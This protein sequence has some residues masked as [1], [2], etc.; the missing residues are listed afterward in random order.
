[1]CRNIRMHTSSVV[2]V[3]HNADTASM[4]IHSAGNLPCGVNRTSGKPFL[5]CH[6]GVRAR[7]SSAAPVRSG[8]DVELLVASPFV[9]QISHANSRFASD[10]ILLHA[11][12]VRIRRAGSGRRL[13]FTRVDPKLLPLTRGIRCF[14][15]AGPRKCCHPNFLVV[16]HALSSNSLPHSGKGRPIR[17]HEICLFEDNHPA[18]IEV[19]K[20]TFRSNVKNVGIIL[21]YFPLEHETNLQ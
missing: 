18:D 19:V 16:C 5:G 1:M 15:V 6:Q 4:P 8:I 10:V 2:G 9:K 3:T 13:Q 12:I 14:W 7:N 21:E 11:R 20:V 17:V